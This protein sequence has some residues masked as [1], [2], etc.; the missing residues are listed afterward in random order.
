MGGLFSKKKG[1]TP[2][3]KPQLHCLFTAVPSELRQEVRT[4]GYKCREREGVPFQLDRRA[5]VAAFLNCHEDVRD[6]TVLSI[7]DVDPR[8]LEMDAKGTGGT[9]KVKTLHA[10][11]IDTDIVAIRMAVDSA[12]CPFCNQMVEIPD[13][14]RRRIGVARYRHQG[15]G[16]FFY[17]GCDCCE[18]SWKLRQQRLDS[19]EKRILYHVTSPDMAAE[20]LRTGRMTRSSSGVAGGALYFA[21]SPQEPAKTATEGAPRSPVVLECEV[22]VGHVRQEVQ[23]AGTD[24]NPE[25]ANITFAQM[26]QFQGN[27]IQI[28]GVDQPTAETHRNEPGPKDSLHLKRGSGE[29]GKSVNEIAVYS[30]DQVKVLRE[31]PA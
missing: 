21:E 2:H 7:R 8:C 3:E 22:H 4:H 30:W 6:I 14:D 18:E 13:K 12:P 27:T 23:Q 11:H 31:I 24:S 15:D 17:I 25:L 16:Q 19:G 10:R 26:M 1:E 9:I 29:S 20:V 28:A 5:A